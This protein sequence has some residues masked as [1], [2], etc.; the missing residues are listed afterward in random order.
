VRAAGRGGSVPFLSLFDGERVRSAII[1]TF[2]AL[3]EMC[4]LRL[5]RVF[6]PD[7]DQDIFIS[8]K[9][10]ALAQFGMEGGSTPSEELDREYE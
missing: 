7:E 9:G 1:I 10:E 3:L 8:E 5:L 6:Q 4:K 2:L